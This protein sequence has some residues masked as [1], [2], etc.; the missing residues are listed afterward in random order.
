MRMAVQRAVVM[1]MRTGERESEAFSEGT[2][3]RV[4]V[5]RLKEKQLRN[6]SFCIWFN[7]FLLDNLAS[8]RRL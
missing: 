5:R 8:S 2:R 4:K 3:I 7:V 6:V 1:M